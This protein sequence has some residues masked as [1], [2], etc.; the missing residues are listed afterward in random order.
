MR[1]AP[2]LV[3]TKFERLTVIKQAE[4]LYGRRSRW[5]CKCRCGNV[6]T[7]LGQSLKSGRVKSCGCLKAEK[8]K[9][10]KN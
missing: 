6:K 9:E 8:L 7:A 3:G 5:I 1:R 2:N 10:Y 4:S